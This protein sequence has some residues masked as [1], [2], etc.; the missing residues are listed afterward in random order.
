MN[1]W[2]G[3]PDDM[4]PLPDW[5]NPETYRRG[6]NQMRPRVPSLNDA[7]ANAMKKPP[8]DLT[9]LNKTPSVGENEE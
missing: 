4:E 2:W 3:E 8:V 6:G 5:M 7:I 1:K 9:Y